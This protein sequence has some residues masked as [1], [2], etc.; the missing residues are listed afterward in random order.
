MAYP[1]T[2]GSMLMTASDN[3]YR[4]GAP[5]D[6][7]T[8]LSLIDTISIDRVFKRSGHEQFVISVFLHHQP[9]K[10]IVPLISPTELFLRT[11]QSR[12]LFSSS[13]SNSYSS[14]QGEPDFETQHRYS[15]FIELRHTLSAIAN[16]A[17]PK[18][19]PKHN[20]CAFCRP[21]LEF[22]AHDRKRPSSGLKMLLSTKTQMEYLASFVRSLVS[23]VVHMRMEG[24]QFQQPQYQHQQQ[25][26]NCCDAVHQAAMVLED[27]L[28]KPKQP[29][30]LGII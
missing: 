6:L 2:R 9:K 5:T 20:L 8:D 3:N 11:R 26:G 28:R 14:D 21:L 12:H 27:F 4:Y 7:A 17:H 29:P 16:S 1:T 22:L 10:T 30:S 18:I 15:D 24:R 19:A 25:R 23:M 13:Y